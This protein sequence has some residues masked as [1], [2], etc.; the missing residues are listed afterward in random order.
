MSKGLEGKHAEA[1]EKISLAGTDYLGYMQKDQILGF[2][3][4]Q[5]K[6]FGPYSEGTG[7][8]WMVL[9]QLRNIMTMVT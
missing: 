8:S 9:E 6:E 4:H 5:V 7:E 3:E 2:L 1:N